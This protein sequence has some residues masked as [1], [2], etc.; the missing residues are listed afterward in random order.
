MVQY[1][2]FGNF[3]QNLRNFL[4]FDLIR[5][6]I[7]A[8][9]C[10]NPFPIHWKVIEW[11]VF[12]RLH[13]EH[14]KL[15]FFFFSKYSFLLLYYSARKTA[16]PMVFIWGDRRYP[17]VVLNT[18]WPLSNIWLLSYERNSFGCFFEKFSILNFFENTQN[19]FPYILATKDR[20]EA[21]LYS[22]RTAGYPLSPHIKTIAVVSLQTE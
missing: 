13:N 7:W 4:N 15:V 6:F 20:S 1:A 19:C 8:A 3:C 12:F 17:D 9:K 16:T 14:P 5:S 22:K 2:I 10:P 18:K 21:V 11:G